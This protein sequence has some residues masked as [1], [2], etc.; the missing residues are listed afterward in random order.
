MERND[1]DILN[2]IE[3]FY[4]AAFAECSWREALQGSV[5]FFNGAGGNL[6][7]LDRQTGQF[8]EWQDYGLEAGSDPYTEHIHSICPRM[9]SSFD[10]PAGFV[11]FDYDFISEREMD[12]HEFYDWLKKIG[13][14]RYFMGMRFYD[15]ERTSTFGSIEFS[16]KH[17]HVSEQDLDLFRKVAP[18]LGR[19]KQISN[20]LSGAAVDRQFSA[21]MQSEVPWGVIG[22]N[23][24]GDVL[25][26]SQ[27]AERIVNQRDG[28]TVRNRRLT[29][30]QAAANRTLQ[31]LIAQ[32]LKASQTIE[33]TSDCRL[34]V[35][36]PSRLPD[37]ALRIVPVGSCDAAVQGELAALVYI[38]DPAMN[39]E[40]NAASLAT[41]FGLT[42]AE[43]RLACGLYNTCSLPKA[44]EIA[45]I[46]HNTAR[47]HLRAILAKTNTASQ[48][49]L[50]KLLASLSQF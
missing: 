25:F 6:F 23:A 9:R 50:I 31:L 49:E 29:A 14:L 41:L 11:D 16:A 12:R 8:E 2:V 37:L 34:P 45:G 4:A 48:L 38:V 1:R 36:R 42:P 18:H 22:L 7:T 33:F 44:A 21:F 13:N 3:R 10:R 39:A 19:A 27:V 20:S 35:A 28:L 43:A 40:L 26:V 17:G 32:A 15:N 24:K 5:E 30:W 47:T 46:S